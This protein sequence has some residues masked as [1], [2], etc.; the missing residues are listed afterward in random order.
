MKIY[1]IGTGYTS[2]PAKISAATE[3]IIE[4]L[5]YAMIENGEDVT[6]ID[7]EDKN[8]KSNSLPITEIKVPLFSDKT[9]TSLGI[10]HK[11]KRVLYSIAVVKKLKNILKNSKEKIFLHFHNQY[12]MFFFLKLTS[13][14][15]R[16]KCICAYTNH[17][18]IWTLD[19][20]ESKDII[21]KRYFQEAECMKKAD[22]LFVLNNKTKENAI[23]HLGVN[24][25]K[26]FLISHGVNTDIYKPLSVEE[27]EKT[28]SEMNLSN[29]KIILQ[30]GSVN[31]N[32]GQK[33]ALQMLLP[34]LK[35]RQDL[36]YAYAGGIV[37]E[38]YQ[39]EILEF[40]KVNK[41][42]NQVKYFG[43]IAPGE[44]LNRIYNIAEATIVPSKFESFCLV[45]IESF[46]A[47]VPVLLDENS[48]FSFSES[49]LLYTAD[50]FEQVIKDNILDNKEQQIK[51][52]K[53]VREN[54]LN[55]YNWN[56][57]AKQYTQI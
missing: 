29:K 20:N 32:K 55:N 13:A 17:S 33:R 22:Y 53:E 41:I 6:I 56:A 36:V 43:M 35:E 8:R 38:N 21:N 40:A 10:I 42:E 54:A 14:K 46:S 37:D 5:T 50:N 9:D 44:E 1:E 48:S 25:D 52:K 34:L 28:K 27:I 47:G 23:N 24:K 31:E 49:A 4:Q 51:L 57:I 7:I 2:I 30:I 45:V 19:W 26:I 12:N 15:E 3:I 39:N 11:I 16:E 18:G